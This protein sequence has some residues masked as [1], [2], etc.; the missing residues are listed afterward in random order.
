MCCVGSVGVGWGGSSLVP[1]SV[2]RG[3]THANGEYQEFL[4]GDRSMLEVSTRNCCQ[5]TDPHAGGEYQQLFSGDISILVVSTR[6]CCQGT[7]PCWW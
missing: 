5:G 4:S 7:Y 2:V 6:N 1:E 3:Q